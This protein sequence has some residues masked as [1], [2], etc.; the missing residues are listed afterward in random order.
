MS[1]KYSESPKSHENY[2]EKYPKKVK[3]QESLKILTRKLSQSYYICS[4]IERKLRENSTMEKEAIAG[5]R[6]NLKIIQYKELEVLKKLNPKYGGGE[7]IKEGHKFSSKNKLESIIKNCEKAE[8]D[9]YERCRT[10][11]TSDEIPEEKEELVDLIGLKLRKYSIYVLLDKYLNRKNHIQR[12]QIFYGKVFNVEQYNLDMIVN[13]INE[14][15]KTLY[16]DAYLV[17]LKDVPIYEVNN[18]NLELID[19]NGRPFAKKNFVDLGIENGLNPYQGK[20]VFLSFFED[21]YNLVNVN[22]SNI[23]WK[24]TYNIV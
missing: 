17:N 18:L 3:N 9:I 16:V 2:N 13:S 11:L 14:D 1:K 5:F 20:R 4:H 6:S 22:T 12:E 24:Y 15:S 21:E 7:F 10:L 8:L 19:A 23:S